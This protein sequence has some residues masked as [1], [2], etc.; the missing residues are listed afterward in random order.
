[1]SKILINRKI[2]FSVS[3][4]IALLVIYVSMHH[5]V[6]SAYDSYCTAI[7]R[8][9]T[10]DFNILAS[11]SIGTVSEIIKSGDTDKAREFGASNY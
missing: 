9:Q 1:M 5:I 2:F 6:R 8:V 10:V 3:V 11:T 4:V 7:D